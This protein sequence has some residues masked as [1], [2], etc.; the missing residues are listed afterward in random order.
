[1]VTGAHWTAGAILRLEGRLAPGIALREL[2]LESRHGTERFDA[3]DRGDDGFAAVLDLG[4]IASLAGLRPLRKG[5]WELRAGTVGGDGQARSVPVMLDRGLL[6]D[7]PFDTVAAHK[8]FALGVGDGDVAVVVTERDLDD[9]ERGPYHQARL[10]ASDDLARRE[11]LLDAV[12]YSSFQGRQYSDSP[13]AIYEELVRRGA[14]LEHLW[15]VRDGR[16][17]PPAGAT[18]VRDGSREHHD[19]LARARYVVVN[20]YFPDFFTRRPDQLCLQTWHGTPLKRLG[21]ELGGLRKAAQHRFARRWEREVENWQYVLS[22]N[23]F[24]TPVLQRAYPI[25]GEMLETGYPRVDVLHRPDRDAL[26]LALRRRLGVPDGVRTVLYAPTYRDHVRDRSG[27]YRLDV[28]LDVER[29]RAAVGGDTVILFRKHHD[30]ADPVPATADGFVRDVSSYPDATE[31]MLAA[32]VL[33]TDYSSAMVDYANTGR[34]MLFYAYDLETFRDETRGF[35]LDFAETVPGPLLGTTDEVIA[36]LGDLDGIRSR[37]AARYEAFVATFC[38]LDDGQ[39]AA[40]VV[41]RLFAAHA[42]A[43]NTS[44]ERLA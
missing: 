6:D 41:D 39:A 34:P 30:V 38:D 42:G 2:T 14:P 8:P 10:R 22:P 7:V 28:H 37:Y 17:L 25:E 32:D 13:R 15:V 26:G 44:H 4:A 11:P 31:L 12:V 29:L 3:V 27:R 19:A 1:V 24:A 33:L 16:C 5:F 23:R 18:V 9:D 20:D 36:A 21:L 35:S 43:A 40:R